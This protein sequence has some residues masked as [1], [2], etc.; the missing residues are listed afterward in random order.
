[1]THWDLIALAHGFITGVVLVVI[2]YLLLN[3]RK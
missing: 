1:M 3:G 2:C